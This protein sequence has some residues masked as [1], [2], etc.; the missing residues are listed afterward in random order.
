MIE[1]PVVAGIVAAGM[2]VVPVNK[3]A[4]A[5]S[6]VAGMALPTPLLVQ[7]RGRDSVAV[8]GFIEDSAASLKMLPVVPS[9]S[10]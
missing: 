2:T 10:V 5:P 8:F 9:L 1:S 6:S 4:E 3:E 7:G